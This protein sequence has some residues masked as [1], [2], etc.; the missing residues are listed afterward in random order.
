MESVAGIKWN[1]WPEWSGITGR[2]HLEYSSICVGAFLLFRPSSFPFFFFLLLLLFF[3]KYTFG[4]CVN[5]TAFE[6][7]FPIV[8]LCAAFNAM[9]EGV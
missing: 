2:D 5:N 7:F 3:Q 8:F 6:A 9:S 1:G 4:L